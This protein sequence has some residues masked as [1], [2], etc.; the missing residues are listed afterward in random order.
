MQISRLLNQDALLLNDLVDVLLK[1]QTSLVIMD[2]DVMEGLLDEKAVL[3]QK[4]T[5]ATKARHLALGQARF[6]PNEDGMTVWVHRHAN[7]KDR[8][9]WQT[10]QQQLAR[11][12]ELN[13]VNGQMIN[14]HFRRNQETLNQL[15][16]APANTSVYGPNG[17]TKTTVSNQS[18][19]MLSV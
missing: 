18:R 14:Q 1:E 9:T 11:A 7:T 16:G 3:L 4:I 17:Q 8:A 5:L 15:Q 19:G 6:E 12:K 10:F 2:I 13:R